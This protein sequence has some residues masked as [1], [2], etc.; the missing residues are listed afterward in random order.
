[1][2]EKELDSIIERRGTDA[3]ALVGILQDVQKQEYCLSVKIL[4]MISEK[5]EVSMSRLY[6]LATFYASAS[7]KRRCYYIG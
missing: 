4:E 7:C 2:T 1:M 3:P 5:I 6:G